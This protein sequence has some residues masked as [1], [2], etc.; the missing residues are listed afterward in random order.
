MARSSI[1]RG[2]P[3]GLMETAMIR[4]RR[5][6]R[7]DILK[8]RDKPGTIENRLDSVFLITRYTSGPYVLGNIV[9][10]NV[11]YLT[12]TPQYR[13]LRSLE[14]KRVFRRPPNLRDMLVRAALPK[15]NPICKGE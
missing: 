14:I 5:Q 12:K 11:P 3:P 6:N 15:N 7:N 10:K 2:Y 8:P 13:D 1:I 4:A 9:Q